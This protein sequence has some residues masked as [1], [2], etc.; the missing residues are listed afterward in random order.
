MTVRRLIAGNWKMNGLRDQ[1]LAYVSSLVERLDALPPGLEL[2]ICPPASLLWGMAERLSHSRL[3]Q[4]QLW[5]GGQDCHW[6][7]THGAYTGE[8]SA[9][10]LYDVGCR[11]VIVGH[12]ECRRAGKAHDL[13]LADKITAAQGA[14]LC[15]ILCVG[16]DEEEPLQA[17]SIVSRQLVQGC[18][19]LSSSALDL[20]GSVT[21]N[22]SLVVAYE[23][24]WA[25]G[26]GRTP[27]VA[28]ID[29]MCRHV[30]LWL[31][32]HLGH[33]LDPGAVRL[34][35]GGSVTAANAPEIL[36]VTDGV[37]VGSVSLSPDEFWAIAASAPG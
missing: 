16:S 35:Y 37:L 24:V 11:F 33:V 8:I 29:S 30:R 23:P 3:W 13:L 4:S 1:A 14:G 9:R 22:R 5:L 21:P 25:I 19:N 36:S 34:L 31:T 2:L 18:S 28:D 17:W 27:E 32:E 12:S 10:M 15:P 26:S 6:H 7:Q 20:S